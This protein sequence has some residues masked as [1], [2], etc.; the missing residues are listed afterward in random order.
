RSTFT[1]DAYVS[2]VSRV[3]EYTRAGDVFQANLSQRFHAPLLGTSLELY[4]RLRARN[5]A[6]FSAYLDYGDVAVASAS[7]ER[8]L[9]ARDGQVEARPIKGTRRRGADLGEDA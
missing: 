1:R 4:E 7:P 2:A 5:P 9:C 8:F 6:P 3:L